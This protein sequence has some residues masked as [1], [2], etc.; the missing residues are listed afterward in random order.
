MAF[1]E[2]VALG[3]L[4][5]ADLWVLRKVREHPSDFLH[6]TSELF[7]L[8]GVAEITTLV[9]VGLLAALSLWGPKVLVGRLLVIFVVTGILEFVMKLLLP[10]VPTPQASHQMD[11]MENFWLLSAFGSPYSYPSG[12][13]LRGVIVLGALCFLSRSRLL[14][15]VVVMLLL[16]LAASRVYLEEHWLSDV[17]GGALLGA[18]ALLW[19][20]RKEGPKL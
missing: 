2:A 14:R 19:A 8:L 17:V 16:G 3:W 11:Q 9:L 4:H 20:F 7:S 5:M 13:M 10:Q 18:S 15:A 12:H 6:W 1:S